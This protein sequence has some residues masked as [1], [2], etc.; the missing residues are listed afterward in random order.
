MNGR[1]SDVGPIENR[2]LE[3][4]PPDEIA[5]ISSYLEPAPLDFKQILYATGGAIRHVYFP[6]SGV[7]CWLSE[8][9]EGNSV[10]VATIGREGIIG[11][12]A[13]FGGTHS[14]VKVMVQ[15]AGEALRM[16]SEDFLAVTQS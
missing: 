2:I 9:D 15:V 5:R 12:H 4:L 11:L 6:I 7:V 13:L 8:I 10:E 14:K 1:G 16:K 3:R